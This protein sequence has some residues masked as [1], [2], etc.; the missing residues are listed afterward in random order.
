LIIHLIQKIVQICKMVSYTLNT[1]DDEV[2]QIK[3]MIY[4]KFV[5]MNTTLRWKVVKKYASRHVL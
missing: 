4:A 1:C 5:R 3:Q 2:S